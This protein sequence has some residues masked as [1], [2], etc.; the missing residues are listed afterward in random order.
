M[1]PQ[2]GPLYCRTVC[3]AFI[4][5]FLSGVTV[6][7]SLDQIPK[8]MR[9]AL[10]NTSH[11]SLPASE[12]AI[13]RYNFTLKASSI[14]HLLTVH[15][16]GGLT[17]LMLGNE[18]TSSRTRIDSLIGLCSKSSHQPDWREDGAVV[19]ACDR[20][21]G[22]RL[23]FTE[24]YIQGQSAVVYCMKKEY[25]RIRYRINWGTVHTAVMTACNIYSNLSQTLQSLC[26]HTWLHDKWTLTSQSGNN[27]NRQFCHSYIP[28]KCCTPEVHLC[29]SCN[30]WVQ[31]VVNY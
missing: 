8:V 11:T 9:H 16:D 27:W 22:W 15:S 18:R 20:E 1:A 13:G 6:P 26:T 17:H 14:C 21:Y 25:T 7:C 30:W 23:H 28:P 29:N 5:V 19:L 12:C 2:L 31:I 4:T 3:S 10:T 24:K